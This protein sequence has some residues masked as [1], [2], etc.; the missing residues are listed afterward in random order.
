MVVENW[1]CCGRVVVDVCWKSM[2][3]GRVI[4]H[5][6]NNWVI[7]VGVSKCGRDKVRLGV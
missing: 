2:N 7:W 6:A 1:S 3:I 4:G 5:V